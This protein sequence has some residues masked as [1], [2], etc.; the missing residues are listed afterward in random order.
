M[1]ITIRQGSALPHSQ[2]S[3]WAWKL[4]TPLDS[5]PTVFDHPPLGIEVPAKLWWPQCYLLQ[6]RWG[7]AEEGGHRL[8]WWEGMEIRRGNGRGWVRRDRMRIS[9]RK[10]NHCVSR[11][12]SLPVP[13]PAV[14]HDLP[15][16]P[17]PLTTP[18]TPLLFRVLPSIPSPLMPHIPT[19]DWKQNTKW[20][21]VKAHIEAGWHRKIQTTMT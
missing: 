5:R 14:A 2:S 17:S 9:R 1:W 3:K 20:H 12:P 13:F 18:L 19:P 7:E 11:L 6:R 21:S 16:F 10:G 15:W 8:G 4:L